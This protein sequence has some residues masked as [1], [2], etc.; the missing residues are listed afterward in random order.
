VLF[1]ARLFWNNANTSF[2]LNRAWEICYPNI[3]ARRQISE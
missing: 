3:R 1:S 2:D